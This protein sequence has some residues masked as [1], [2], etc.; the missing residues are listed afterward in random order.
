MLVWAALV[1]LGIDP[2]RSLI[3]FLIAEAI[4]V[5]VYVR[6]ARSR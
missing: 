5:V 1:A 6:Q 3:P 4:A 2:V